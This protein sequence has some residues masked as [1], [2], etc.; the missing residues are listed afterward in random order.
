MKLQQPYCSFQCQ[1]S[2]ASHELCKDQK[3]SLKPINCCCS[4]N[5]LEGSVPKK[6][7]KTVRIETR[8]Q[9]LNNFRSEM[10]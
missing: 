7:W 9:K 4:S 6:I 8:K 3:R 10:E 5:Q 2:S 1:P